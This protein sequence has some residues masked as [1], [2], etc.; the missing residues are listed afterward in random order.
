MQQRIM[1]LQNP[2]MMLHITC[3]KCNEMG[4]YANRCPL[5]KVQ[6]ESPARYSQENDDVAMAPMSPT[7]RLLKQALSKDGCGNLSTQDQTQEKSPV[8][9][10]QDAV[11]E[12]CEADGGADRNHQ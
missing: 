9:G 1:Q 12:D 11:M 10:T 3:N 7:E 4:H 2:D 5:R 6:R 8:K